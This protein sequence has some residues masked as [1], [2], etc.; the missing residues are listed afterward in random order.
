[1]T[2]RLATYT[3]NGTPLNYDESRGT[4][5]V[6][7]MPVTPER[8]HE[9]NRL[10]HFEWDVDN[11][12]WFSASFPA[13]DPSP[14]PPRET[15]PRKTEA[16]PRADSAKSGC[17]GWLVGPGMTPQ[18]QVTVGVYR[19]VDVAGTGYRQK[20]LWGV[21]IKRGKGIQHEDYVA[22]LKPEP[23]N[24]HDPNAV[25]VTSKGQHIGYVPKYLNQKLRIGTFSLVLTGGVLDSAGGRSAIEA[26]IHVPMDLMQ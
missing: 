18:R 9:I 17:L 12:A 19:P 26:V 5:D 20:E 22:V 4:F 8:V 10:G 16:T 2:V 13:L 25:R 3:I 23:K 11:L 24:Q 7:G 1:M 15:P 21:A 14:A 6:G